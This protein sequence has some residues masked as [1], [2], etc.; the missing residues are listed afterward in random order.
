MESIIRNC[1][2]RQVLLCVLFAF[3]AMLRAQHSHS[4]DRELVLSGDHSWAGTHHVQSLKLKNHA[5]LFAEGDLTI[6]SVG[7]IEIDGDLIAQQRAGG[8]AWQLTLLAGGNVYLRGYIGMQ[9]GDAG[10]NPESMYGPAEGHEFNGYGG[11]GLRVEAENILLANDLEAGNGGDASA[12]GCGGEG[13]TII[14]S[15]RGRI[16]SADRHKV[17]VVRGGRGGNGGEGNLLSAYL[18][19]PV[20]ALG[21]MNPVERVAHGGDAG[22][23]G[24]VLLI[25]AWSDSRL[26]AVDGIAADGPNGPAGA[27]VNFAG[28]VG[29]VG[30]PGPAAAGGPGGNGGNGTAPGGKGGNGGNGGIGHGGDGA[31]GNLIW[32]GGPG[33][34]GTGGTGG[35]GGNAFVAPNGPTFAGGA[36]GDG[37]AGT[38][39]DGGGNWKWPVSWGGAGAAGTGG[40]GGNGGTGCGGGRGGNGGAGT[41]GHSGF[42]ASAQPA[43]GAGTG[44]AGG[45][46]GTGL[47]AAGVPGGH[48]AC[49]GG[50]GGNGGDATGGNCL[51][52]LAVGYVSGGTAGNATSGAGGAGGAG[53]SGT[54]GGDP[55]GGAS[56]GGGGSGGL[57]IAGGIAYTPFPGKVSASDAG[58]GTAI[59]GAGGA[60]GAG[61]NGFGPRSG[62]FGG[63]GGSGGGAGSLISGNGSAVPGTATGGAG[64]GGGAGGSGGDGLVWGD[65]GGSGGWGGSGGRGGNGVGSAGGGGGAGTDAGGPGGNATA[66]K[67]GC[68]GDGGD[69]GKG[70]GGGGG[71][72]GPAGNGG[73]SGNA[74]GGAGGNGLVPGT[75]FGGPSAAGPGGNATAWFGSF[76]GTPGDGGDVDCP[77]EQPG[78]AG[79]AGAGGAAGVATGGAAGLGVPPAL[80]G[81]AW[82]GAGG[83]CPVPGAGVA[84][85]VLNPNATPDSL[86]HDND[87]DGYGSTLLLYCGPQPYPPGY[88]LQ[89]GDCNDNADTIN[90]GMT[91]KCNGIDD[92]C[93]GLVDDGL[94]TYTYYHDN[95][96]DGYG[97]EDFFGPLVTCDSVA[98]PGYVDNDDDCNDY[99]DTINPGMPEK[100]NGIDDNC[101]GQVDEGFPDLT[102]FRDWDNDG[103]GDPD[104]RLVQCDSTAPEGYVQDST[105]CDD[106]DSLVN[107]GA[108]EVCNG[109]DDDCDG[110]VD[111]GFPEI[112]V[113][114]DADNDGHGDDNMSFAT[115]DTA[116]FLANGYVLQGGDCDDS[117]ANVYPGAPELCNYRDDD[118]DGQIDEGIILT[119]YYP[120]NDG[121]GFG[122]DGAPWMSCGHPGP[123]YVLVGGDC[124]DW[125][126]TIYP[127]ATEVCN[128]MDD[129][130]D[131]QIDEGLSFTT[132]YP[133]YDG[134]GYGE[135]TPYMSCDTPGMGYVTTGGDCDDY[136]PNVYPGAAEVCCN[137]MDD[138]CDGQYDEG[139]G[140]C[141]YYKE[142]ASAEGALSVDAVPN[143][144]ER[145]VVLHLSGDGRFVGGE[146]HDIRGKLVYT[147]GEADLRG[148]GSAMQWTPGAA[149]GNGTYYLK[150]FIQSGHQRMEMYQRVVL[151]R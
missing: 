93:N 144:F 106:L 32:T 123:G 128:Y 81:A 5:R 60:G 122:D 64:G 52:V 54:V 34:T 87:S 133:D 62:G 130:C 151:V 127:G 71:N 65:A 59:G 57:A 84:G 58:S 38:G 48:G 98:P 45:A 26:L 28:W 11:G 104:S 99:A 138:N 43:A 69:G 22:N 116:W 89:G 61:G 8:D 126:S 77:G 66:G 4:G 17:P 76:A 113:F 120:D 25:A 55:H 37:G 101:D 15:A 86:Y 23:G 21:V 146:V 139:C 96:S 7:D 143:P 47:N 29:A 145:S 85:T 73:G 1:P 136:D 27:N 78:A 148:A 74:T 115:C 18:A 118:C 108:T 2:W 44:G 94:P 24:D 149:V 117:D 51:K 88:V 125:D 40:A 150:M 80:A 72:G 141:G 53:G 10:A 100:C 12:G 105:D 134:D 91:E 75:L 92:D 103:Y 79:T 119:T 147:F 14:L 129:N 56:G 124:N 107:P 30:T 95:D 16:V 102:W 142:A 110:E 114:R 13:G 39:G 131:G 41:G 90:P 112:D 137:Y 121:D 135:D 83:G 109:W 35:N 50:A 82:V 111:E 33:G 6:V 97:A 19:Q 36:G 49:S 68:G 3:P 31:D 9:N 42:G 70:K 132:W 67:G 140:N 20:A 63:N 46:G